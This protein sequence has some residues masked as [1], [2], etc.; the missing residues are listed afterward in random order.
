MNNYFEDIDFGDRLLT[1][2]REELFFLAEKDGVYYCGLRGYWESIPYD[3]AGK[4]QLA[5]VK[6]IDVSDGRM[7]IDERPSY[8]TELID[9]MTVEELIG[10]LNDQT[11]P[12]NPKAHI[13]INDYFAPTCLS[14]DN[15]AYVHIGAPRLSPNPYLDELK[16]KYGLGL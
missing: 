3:M 14:S 13:I 6:G 11:T 1:K 16:E 5:E 4:C 15:G 8:P 10:I 12:V 7:D 9:T 2:S